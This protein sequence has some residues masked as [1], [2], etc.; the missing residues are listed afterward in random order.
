MPPWA[1]PQN[2]DPSLPFYTKN[3]SGYTPYIG[4]GKI[5]GFIYDTQVSVIFAKGKKYALASTP[6]LSMSQPRAFNFTGMMTISQLT[7]SARTPRTPSRGLPTTGRASIASP[8]LLYH[9]D[10]PHTTPRTTTTVN[11]TSTSQGIEVMIVGL[12]EG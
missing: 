2:G 8:I 10:G 3:S 4:K 5:F 12:R 9:W 1:H 7:A 6:S 11:V